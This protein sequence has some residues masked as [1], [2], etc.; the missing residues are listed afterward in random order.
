MFIA[1]NFD[2]N[3][4]ATARKAKDGIAP[5]CSADALSAFAEV[6]TARVFVWFCV[7][8]VWLI[9]FCATATVQSAICVGLISSRNRTISLLPNKAITSPIPCSGE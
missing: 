2:A 6:A 4:C 7:A 1:A 9:C 5:I 8:L 3:S